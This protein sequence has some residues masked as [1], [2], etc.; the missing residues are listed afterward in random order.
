[1]FDVP[2]IHCQIVNTCSCSISTATLPK[3]WK[4][5]ILKFKCVG[6]GD[7]WERSAAADFNQLN[8]LRL[9]HPHLLLKTWQ[10]YKVP[11]QSQRLLSLAGRQNHNTSVLTLQESIRPSEVT[12]TTL[13]SGD[14]TATFCEV[15]RS[16]PRRYYISFLSFSGTIKILNVGDQQASQQ[17]VMNKPRY[18]TSQ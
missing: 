5:S 4:S 11:P 16:R 2:L 17:N 18:S 13:V 10:T 12:Q 8:T 14:H 9:T 1:M 15:L 7:F 6:W 3:D